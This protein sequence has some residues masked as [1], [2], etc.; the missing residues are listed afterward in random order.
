[1]SPLY[2]VGTTHK[3][4]NKKGLLEVFIELEPSQLLLE[5]NEEDIQSCKVK[6]HP[7]EMS[8]A[9]RWGLE[10]KKIVNGFDHEIPCRY[11]V[12]IEE[13]PS[14][15]APIAEEYNSYDFRKMNKREYTNIM[16]DIEEQI[17]VEEDLLNRREGMVRNIRSLRDPSVAGLVLTG[18][19]HLWFFEKQLPEAIFPYRV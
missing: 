3:E 5:L 15:F 9:Y 10:N 8:W 4:H 14:F 7:V 2:I 16:Q 13:I 18:V 12:P 1:M 6:S 17:F 19:G 11:K